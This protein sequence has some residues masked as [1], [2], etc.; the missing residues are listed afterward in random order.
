MRGG[1]GEVIRPIPTHTYP[2][3]ARDQSVNCHGSAWQYFTLVFARNSHSGSLSKGRISLIHLHE[4]LKTLQ[5]S[6]F[7]SL[8]A[9]EG[10]LKVDK[11][12]KCWRTSAEYYRPAALKVDT[13]SLSPAWFEQAHEVSGDRGNGLI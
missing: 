4:R 9:L 13:V 7:G 2:I 8:T 11:S 3:Q 6:V 10:L 1:G 5:S 12:K